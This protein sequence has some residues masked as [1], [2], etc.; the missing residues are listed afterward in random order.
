VL[1]ALN[2]ALATAHPYAPL[3]RWVSE[4]DWRV[5]A[6]ARRRRLQ[7]KKGGGGVKEEEEKEGGGNGAGE[8]EQDEEQEGRAAGKDVLHVAWA[9]LTDSTRTQLALRYHPHKVAAAALY[10]SALLVGLL[11]L[12]PPRAAGG[13]EAAAGDGNGNGSDNDDADARAAFF[14]R[15]RIS[16]TELDDIVTEMMN[17]SDMLCAPRVAA[18]LKA[19]GLADGSGGGEGG[20]GGGGGDKKRPRAEGEEGKT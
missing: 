3:L 15:F 9:L 10:T 17:S 20:G 6:R 12:P 7:E 5:A 18:K 19:E 16:A 8:Q 13:G 11:P 1:F 14:R 4:L 2:F